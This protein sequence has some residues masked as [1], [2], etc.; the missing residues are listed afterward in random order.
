MPKPRILITCAVVAAVLAGGVW[1]ARAPLLE[2]AGGVLVRDEGDA[3]PTNY[4]FVLLGDRSGMRARRALDAWRAGLAPVIAFASDEKTGLVAEGYAPNDAEVHV[5]FLKANGVP[6][7][8][9][10]ALPCIVASTK[11]EAECFREVVSKPPKPKSV[12]IVTSWYHTSRAGWMFDRT[13]EGTG[14]TPRMLAS[15]SAESTPANWWLGEQSFLAVMAELLKW[16]Y[17]LLKY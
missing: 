9:I 14:V 5:A 15:K 17:Y 12:Y 2:A 6:D 3:G 8:S 11:D 4:I 1:L 16:S 7:A 10:V 13:F